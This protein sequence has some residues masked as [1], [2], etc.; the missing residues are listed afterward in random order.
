M[1][2]CSGPAPVFWWVML[3]LKHEKL[4][5]AATGTLHWDPQLCR[6]VL[7]HKAWRWTLTFSCDGVRVF[8]LFSP[9]HSLKDCPYSG[10]TAPNVWWLPAGHGAWPGM[11]LQEAGL[12][13]T[14]TQVHWLWRNQCLLT[15]P[16]C[17]QQGLCASWSTCWTYSGE[18][19]WSPVSACLCNLRALPMVKDLALSL[20]GHTHP[21]IC[22]LV[23]LGQ[24]WQWGS[25][26]G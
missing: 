21:V 24:Q 22:S 13:L 19:W 25:P 2:P 7:L 11:A 4:W 5:V 20:Q 26:P 14:G 15:L 8:T 10:L 23:F 3:D 9:P 18:V 1:P 16:M 6:R 12:A 17:G